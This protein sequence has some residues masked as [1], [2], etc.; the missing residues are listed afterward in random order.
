MESPAINNAVE[1]VKEFVI[2]GLKYGIDNL[3]HVVKDKVKKK[4]L[5]LKSKSFM[6]MLEML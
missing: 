4:T 3:G 5:L 2:N 6:D 1:S